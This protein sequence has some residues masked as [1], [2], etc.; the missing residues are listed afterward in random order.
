MYITHARYILED[1]S[2]FKKL[3][4]YCCKFLYT[5]QQYKAVII[6]LCC[7]VILLKCVDGGKELQHI[8]SDYNI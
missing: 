1:D 8:V 2:A 6:E 5:E 7:T 4:L 3:G